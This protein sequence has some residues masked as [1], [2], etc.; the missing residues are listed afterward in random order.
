MN[1]IRSLLE[2][3][4]ARGEWNEIFKLLKEKKIH[5][6][7]IL[8]PVTLYFKSEGEIKTFSYKQKL[9]KFVTR[10]PA[11]KEMLIEVL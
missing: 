2:I 9:W 10:R 8:Y 7:R 5:L 1:Y 11:L 4:Q 6:P 3:M